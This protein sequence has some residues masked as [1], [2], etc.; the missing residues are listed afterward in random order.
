MKI[1][2]DA[3]SCPVKDIIT[4]VAQKRNIRVILIASINHRMLAAEGVQVITVDDSPQSVDIMLANQ[5][6][7][8]DIVVTQDWGLAA[9][10]LGKKAKALSPRGLIF[11]NGNIDELLFVRH[12]AAKVR[13]AGG[14]TKGP[15]AFVNADKRN[16]QQALETMIDLSWEEGS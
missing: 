14:R 1:L 12:L 11:N 8:G 2:V 10:V 7:P 15:L 9:L 13:R 4:A 16:F 6:V 3:D 5:L